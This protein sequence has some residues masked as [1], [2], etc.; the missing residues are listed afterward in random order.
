MPAT[1]DPLC[2]PVAYL[3]S[4]AGCRHKR[5]QK[6]TKMSRTSNQP[7]RK[8]PLLIVSFNNKNRLEKKKMIRMSVKKLKNIRDPESSLYKAVL[9]NNTL[10]S[11]R[12]TWNTKSIEMD[13]KMSN[14]YINTDTLTHSEYSAEEEQILNRIML[15]INDHSLDK[16]PILKLYNDTSM[17]KQISSEDEIK[18]VENYE[19]IE[20]KEISSSNLQI[21]NF[22]ES[23]SHLQKDFATCS[24]SLHFLISV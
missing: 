12:N 3:Q 8:S 23:S 13:N 17:V 2:D 16:Q 7:V 18:T 14:N 22:K 21:V 10:E 20:E 11:L 4:C 5:G 1:G 9:I 6:M 24:N 19:N 15:P